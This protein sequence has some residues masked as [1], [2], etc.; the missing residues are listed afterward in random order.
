[1]P[2]TKLSQTLLPLIVLIF[3]TQ[4]VHPAEA[5]NDWTQPCFKGVCSYDLPATPN[6]ASGTLKIVCHASA[7]DPI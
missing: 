6:G 3:S 4:F 5:A 2:S 7:R 1:M